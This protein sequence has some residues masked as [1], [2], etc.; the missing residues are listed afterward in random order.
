MPRCSIYVPVAQQIKGCRTFNQF[1]Q[2][3]T[4]QE[5]YTYET[6]ISIFVIYVLCAM[7]NRIDSKRPLR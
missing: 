3:V 6:E 2:A 1:Y 5:D 7:L 4:K